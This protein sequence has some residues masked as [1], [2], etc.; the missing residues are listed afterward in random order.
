MAW[1]VQGA[2]VEQHAAPSLV[3]ALEEIP[4]DSLSLVL[5]L[6]EIPLDSLSLVLALEE[7]PLDSLSLVLAL[8]EIPL[9]SLSLVLALEEIPRVTQ[10]IKNQLSPHLENGCGDGEG[11][12]GNVGGA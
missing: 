1:R 8:E 9:D 5:A 2:H 7:I 6:E 4:L 12:I 10:R 3:L 11:G